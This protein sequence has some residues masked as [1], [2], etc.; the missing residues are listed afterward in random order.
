VPSLE[1]DPIV[2]DLGV[3]FTTC[4]EWLRSDAGQTAKT[5]KPQGYQ[6]I[7]LYAKACQ[8]LQKA[9]QLQT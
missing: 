7:Y 1:P 3:A 6:N 8:Q 9:E 2:D 4:Q 5:D